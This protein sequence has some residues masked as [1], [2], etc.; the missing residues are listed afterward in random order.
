MRLPHAQKGVI[1]ARRKKRLAE[2][3]FVTIEAQ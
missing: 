3:Q 2:K 1:S